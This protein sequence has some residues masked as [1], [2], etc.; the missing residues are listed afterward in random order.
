MIS[1]KTG[2]AVGMVFLLSI[3]VI[4]LVQTAQEKKS[5][6]KNLTILNAED[7]NAENEE[8]EQKNSIERA[9]YEWLLTRDPKTGKIPEGIRAKELAWLKTMPIRRNGL[10]NPVEIPKSTFGST[11]NDLQF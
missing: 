6:S 11:G 5:I 1:K 3:A 10:F 9:R 7:D 2:I 8:L 4:Y